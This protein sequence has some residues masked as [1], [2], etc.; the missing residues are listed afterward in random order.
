MKKLILVLLFL[1]LNLFAHPVSYTIDLEVSYDEI[2]KEALVKCK[3]N[4]KNKC[5][6]YSVKLLD[7]DENEIK[8]KRFPFL[9]A[10]LKL[11]IDKK[12]KKLI[13]FLRKIPEHTYIKIFED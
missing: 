13:F 3:S 11:Q 5:G 8:T 7:A 12:P 2:L 1:A 4:S 6:L 10:Q 9:R